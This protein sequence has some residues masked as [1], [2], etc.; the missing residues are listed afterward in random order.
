[1]SGVLREPRFA[2][3]G[4]PASKAVPPDFAHPPTSPSGIARGGGVAF[5]LSQ[6]PMP[7]L[8]RHG[9]LFLSRSIAFFASESQ[10]K[11]GKETSGSLRSP[12]ASVA[13]AGDDGTTPT[14]THRV[15]RAVAFGVR[16]QCLPACIG[17][18]FERSSLGRFRAPWEGSKTPFAPR[19]PLPSPK[20]DTSF[21]S[22][23]ATKGAKTHPLSL[24]WG[25]KETGIKENAFTSIAVVVSTRRNL[26][27]Q[28]RCGCRAFALFPSHIDIS[29]R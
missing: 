22:P 7:R 1:M 13:A 10:R 16:L 14:G 28:D 2:C 11:L 27:A 4:R 24:A 5:G 18:L 19:Y 6:S 15:P 21:C 20:G 29:P 25:P 12:A 3:S 26:S 9:R 17:S 8:S 23:I